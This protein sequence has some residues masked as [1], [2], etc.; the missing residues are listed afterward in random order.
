MKFCTRRFRVNSSTMGYSIASSVVFKKVK[1]ALGLT[2][3]VTFV[4]AAAPLSPD[5]KK[6][7]FSVDLP[8]MEAFG[9]SE[10]AGAHTLC[11]LDGGFGMDTIGLTIS[12]MK[13]KIHQP[14]NLGNGELCMYG[15]H[16][17]MGYL[18][19]HQKTIDTVDD[20]GWLHSGDIG[21]IDDKGLV[22]ITGRLK[23]LLITAG[24]ENVAPVP[25]EQNIKAELQHISNCVLIGD[26]KKFLSLLITL[27][28]EI[29]SE[30]TP[31]DELT[32]EVKGWLQTLGCPASTV[33]EVLADGPNPK[34]LKN[35]QGALDRVNAKAPSNA[36][37]IQKFKILPS[38]FSVPTGELGKLL[39]PTLTQV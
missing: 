39:N 38:D 13:T 28:T 22:Y 23:E 27:K 25:I 11:V 4:S 20:E 24:G 7:F 9:M 36:Q 32:N 30:G 19:E 14:D 18:N 8:V 15:R 26:K 29:D 35:I 31:K 37:K 6:Y 33:S 5:V 12:G 21:K 10:A 16:I 17:F 1:E 34:L 3:C 2:R